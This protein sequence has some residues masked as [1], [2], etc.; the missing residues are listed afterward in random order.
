M[1]N[2]VVKEKIYIPTLIKTGRKTLFQIIA[3]GIF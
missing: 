1:G 3:L 2:D